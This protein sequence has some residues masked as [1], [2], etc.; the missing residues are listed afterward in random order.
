MMKPIFY[1][2]L[3]HP[4]LVALP[5]LWLPS[6]QAAQPVN[7]D[8]PSASASSV[9]SMAPLPNPLPGGQISNV[10]GTAGFELAVPALDRD[11]LT[12]PR[13]AKPC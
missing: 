8:V 9:R 6:S 4:L 5:W 2:F 1:R 11:F 12:P 10:S 13:E 7:R 3:P